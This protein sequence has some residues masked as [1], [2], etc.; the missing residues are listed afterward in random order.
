[1]AVEQPW[2]RVKFVE[3]FQNAQLFVNHDGDV[4]LYR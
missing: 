1:M 3:G 2:W 4:K